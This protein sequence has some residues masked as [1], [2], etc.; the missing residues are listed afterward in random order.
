MKDFVERLASGLPLTFIGALA[1]V[2]V[3]V[4]LLGD[5]RPPKP[6]RVLA[7]V[8][9]VLLLGS[10]GALLYGEPSA[11]VTSVVLW[12]TLGMTAASFLLP[13]LWKCVYGKNSDT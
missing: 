11:R 5:V 13:L 12:F 2:V 10:W 3:V 9:L 7:S 6:R 8:W 4:W 1:I